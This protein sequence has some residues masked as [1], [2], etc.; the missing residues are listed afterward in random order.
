[1][2]TQAKTSETSPARVATLRIADR[3]D[4]CGAQAYASAHLPGAEHPLLFCGHHYRK[5]E[6]GLMNADARLVDERWRLTE[7]KLK[8]EL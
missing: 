2:T 6:A 1:M 5:Y 8:G 4:R 3:C 7:D